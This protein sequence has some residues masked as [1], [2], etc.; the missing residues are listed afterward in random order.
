MSKNRGFTIIE[1]VVII[2][3]IGVLISILLP[4]LSAAKKATYVAAC[5]GNLQQIGIAIAAYAVVYTDLIPA[6]P[7]D[8]PG[9]VPDMATNQ[10]WLPSNQPAGLGLLLDGFLDDPRALYDPGDDTLDPSEE[11]EKITGKLGVAAFS[12]YFYRQLDQTTQ[13]RIGGLGRNDAGRPARALVLDANSLGPEQ[14]SFFR[15]NHQNK[16]VNIL[17]LDGHVS[18]HRN[19]DDAFSLR[20][21][22]FTTFISSGFTDRTDLEARLNQILVRADFAESGEVEDAPVLP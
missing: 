3:I 7:L 10:V 11:L 22:D 14:F 5:G 21:E 6:G 19:P 9:F 2:G 12:S 15:T 17:Y 18:Q 4:A 13:N 16:I 20:N 1:L 8:L